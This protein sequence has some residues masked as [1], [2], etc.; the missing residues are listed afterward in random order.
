MGIEKVFEA[1]LRRDAE[2]LRRY[3]PKDGEKG[4]EAAGS[5]ELT[6]GNGSRGAPANGG[7][8]ASA[9]ER[10]P[11]CDN[12]WQLSTD[13]AGYKY[14]RECHCVAARRARRQLMQSGLAGQVERCSFDSFVC[15]SPWQQAMLRMAQE[16]AAHVEAKGSRWLYI[17]GQVGCGKTH[18]CTAVCGRLLAAGIPLRYMLWT[19]EARRIKAC[20]TES[21]SYAE[22]LAPLKTAK[23]LYIDD[24]AKC[25]RGA[26]YE[27]RLSDGDVRLAFELINYR[28]INRLPT[29]ISSE[30]EIS[31]LIDADQATFS[32]V[33]EMA[34]GYTLSIAPDPRKNYRIAGDL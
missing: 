14:A 28:Y 29:I 26:E 20:V 30:W 10:C 21:E 16:Y 11:D 8:L 3:L 18:I 23:L 31:D 9:S 25:R 27:P 22:L 6:S 1:V 34:K 5:A 4:Q 33:Y 13:E 12:G 32:R 7:S 24:L 19:E 2:E 15:K 17:G